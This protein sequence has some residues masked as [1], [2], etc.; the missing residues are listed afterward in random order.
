MHLQ[1]IYRMNAFITKDGNGRANSNAYITGE[2][3]TDVGEDIF[4]RG[5]CLPSDNKMSEEEQDV[6]I[7]II[8]KCFE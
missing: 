2:K 3:P 7:E 1:P 4:Q 5:L 6:I 8:R